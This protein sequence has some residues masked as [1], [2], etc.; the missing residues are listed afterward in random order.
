VIYFLNFIQVWLLAFECDRQALHPVANR[1]DD[2]LKWYI[3][4]TL[5]LVKAF[6]HGLQRD[7]GFQTGEGSTKTEM[8]A[9]A[10]AEAE[11]RDR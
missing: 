4:Y 1:A 3:G 6:K 11:D 2:G 8:N 7:F 5:Y 9:V 10:E